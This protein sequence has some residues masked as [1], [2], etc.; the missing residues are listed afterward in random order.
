[1]NLLKALGLKEKIIL[2]LSVC[3]FFACGVLLFNFDRIFF[4]PMVHP[5]DVLGELTRK[6]GSVNRRTPDMFEFMNL[7]VKDKV[8]NGDSIFTGPAASAT[9]VM[10]EESRIFLG[11]NTLVVI[12]ENN[13]KFNIKIEK[14]DVSGDISKGTEIEFQTDEESIMLNGEEFSSLAMSY[15]RSQ[16]LSIRDVKPANSGGIK[17]NESD[18]ES[19]PRRKKNKKQKPKNSLAKDDNKDFRVNGN[20][21]IPDSSKEALQKKDKPVRL[22]ASLKPPESL[23]KHSYKA[24]YPGNDKVLLHKASTKVVLLPKEKCINPCQIKVWK[25]SKLMLRREF[26]PDRVPILTI[27]IDSGFDATVKWKMDEGETVNRGQFQIRKFSAQSF[28]EA[29]EAGYN[30]EVLD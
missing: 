20:D 30:I 7:F 18:Q 4:K 15:T 2:I 9:L 14:G 25:N 29:L 6:K 24:P 11:S 26:P 22:Q 10:I 28:K 1:M 13:G 23:N 17:E 8:G 21:Q 12:R 3:S 27:P 19:S 16:G 5:D